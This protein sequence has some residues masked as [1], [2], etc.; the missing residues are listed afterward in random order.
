MEDPSPLQKLRE[1]MALAVGENAVF[2][3]WGR[4]AVESAAVKLGIDPA[5]ARLAFPKTQAGMIDA[6][7]EAVDRAMSS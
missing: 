6:Y 7:I 2:D 5:Q 4:D 3:G 1:R